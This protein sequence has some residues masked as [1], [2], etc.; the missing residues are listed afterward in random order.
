MG[1]EQ[2]NQPLL[3]TPTNNIPVNSINSIDGTS[4]IYPD[5]SYQQ[6]P[7][8]ISYQ[9]SPIAGPLL[10]VQCR[11]CSAPIQYTPS[12]TSFV[13][14]CNLC[15]HATQVGPPLPGK[16][17]ILCQ[18]NSLLTYRT[19]ARAVVCPK[20]DC[21]RNII[22]APPAPGQK[23]AF[24]SHCN[25][26][27]TFKRTSGMVVC[28]MCKHG[29]VISRGTLTAYIIFLYFFAFV[30]LGL[31]IVLAILSEMNN[32]YWFWGIS[33][34]GIFWLVRAIMLTVRGCNTPDA[35]MVGV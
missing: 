29:S 4:A 9:Q 1:I 12:P 19:G 24:C 15:H 17:V 34:S 11:V 18:C 33:V 35:V 5:P 7:P 32:T 21:K 30:F 26:L 10:C 13:V 23:R 6:Q 28:P 25:Q 14:V 20:V 8:P 31:G 2:E 27:L 16:S 22:L 3:T